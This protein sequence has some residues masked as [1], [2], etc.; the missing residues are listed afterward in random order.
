MRALAC[1]AFALLVGGSAHAGTFHVAA[2]GSDSAAGTEAAPWKT[3]QHA[4]DRVAAGD[5]V[6]VHAGG[7][8]GFSIETSGT[9][10]APIAFVAEGA[11]MIDGAATAGRDAI[12]VDGAS[13]IRIEGFTITGAQRAGVSALECDHVTVRNNRIDQSGTWGV[14][15]G[16]CDDLVV[17]N[18]EI[19]RS[20]AQHGIYASNS[21]DR[22]V[23]RGNTIYG[24]AMAGI[25]I[26]GDGSQG[27]DGV[28]S[29]AIVEG[30]IIYDNGRSGGSGINC[31]GVTNSTIRNNLLD[32]NHASGI[33]LYAIDGS[34]PSTGNKVINNT[35][36]MAS[37]GRWAVNIQ[38]GS[39]GNTLRNN[40]L[41][42]ASPN[43]GAVDICVACV[44]GTVSDHN[45]VVGKFSI[46]GTVVD[47]AGWRTRTGDA[48]SFVATDAELFT[49]S[50]DLTLRAG[51]PAIDAG[52]PEDAPAVDLAGTPRPQGASI[53]VGA[54]E[55]CEGE[56]GPGPGDGDGDGDPRDNDNDPGADEAGGCAT[57]N[58]SGLAAIGL[59]LVGLVLLRRR[60]GRG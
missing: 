6:T 47:L 28:I 52:M 39:G 51:S 56:C 4:A 25:H 44:V 42:H 21:A 11:V 13:Y 33:S 20:A 8:V 31:D 34:A 22:P 3:I 50:D 46:D 15:S 36:R 16:F 18:N 43:R 41:L 53:D 38:D 10:A 1:G 59:G 24:N 55:H 40:I 19:S 27:G 26:N 32:G 58:P 48:G 9:S 30:N 37:D 7:Y 49:A 5:T 54:Y 35:I 14:F 23:I 12:A 57:S 17:E 2:T 29:D 45:A 60:R